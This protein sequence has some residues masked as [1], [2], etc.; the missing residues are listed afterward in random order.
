[1]RDW[2]AFCQAIYKGTEELH[3]HY[4]EMS[5]ATGGKTPS[6]S[7]KGEALWAMKAAWDKGE[8]HYDPARKE[9]ILGRT[10]KLAW[11]CGKNISK[12]RL[13]PWQKRW[14]AWK[15]PTRV[16]T[17]FHSVSLPAFVAAMTFSIVGAKI[18]QK[19]GRVVL[20][21]RLA[22]PGSMGRGAF[23]HIIQL[24]ECSKGI[25]TTQRASL[26]PH[27]EGASFSHEGRALQ[28]LCLCGNAQ[29]V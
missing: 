9:D 8:E 12:T 14:N 1:M 18:L 7:Q 19:M 11:I 16:A 21:R 28:V 20:G 24:L 5:K 25:W 15:I 6:E 26:L 4:R 3:C 10:R 13:W 23:T 2:R 29:G 27:Q 17:W 22:L